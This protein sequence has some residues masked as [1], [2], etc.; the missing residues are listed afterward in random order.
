MLPFIENFIRRRAMKTGKGRG[1]F[2]RVARSS[3]E[4]GDYLSKWGGLYSCGTTPTINIGCNITDPYLVRIGNNCALSACTLLGHDAVVHL[5]N[6]A[7]GLKLDA[8]GFIDIRDNSFIGHGA[9]IMPNV[10][11]GPNAVVAAGSVVTK[12]VAPGTVVG[13]APAKVIGS[14]DEMV[15][16]MKKRS[17]SYPWIDLIEKRQGSFDAELEPR[18]RKMRAEH[19][20]G[21][22]RAG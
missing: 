11:I 14:F 18:L 15:E 4:W 17:A 1:L 10:R 13:G 12:D 7:Q 3:Q 8:V 9:I 5:I 6:R 22:D 20:F 2:R 21:N 16:R 19:F